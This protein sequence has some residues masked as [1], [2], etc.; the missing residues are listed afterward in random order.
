[1]IMG[2]TLDYTHVKEVYAR[3]AELGVAIP[4]F[5]AEDR[6]TMEAI[7]AAA[8]ELG[9]EIGVPDLPVAPA[10]TCRYPGRKQM[11]LVT[12]CGDP[13]LG[14]EMMHSDLRLFA[15]EHSPYRH[16]TILPHLDHAFPWYDMDVLI[17]YA[18][19]FASVM[20]DAS[21]RPFDE[22]IE[23]T[24]KYVERVKGKVVVEGGV[25]EVFEATGDKHKN[26][27]TTVGQAKRFLLE[28]GVDIIVP[29]VGTEHRATADKVKYNSKRAREISKKVGKIMCLHGTSSVPKED[30]ST[31]P[32]DG[33]VKINIF[34]ILAVK[35]GQS[36]ADVVL[37]NL[38]NIFTY[39]Q[40]EKYVSEGLL[41]ENVLKP[42][43]A[44]A[45]D[46][47]KPRLN[48]AANPIRRGAWFTIVKDICKDYMRVFN[49]ERYAC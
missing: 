14:M 11:T 33:F 43:Y 15:G 9:Q 6:E 7:L 5:C 35:G 23:I 18:D 25:D 46:G 3:A 8:Y 21:E 13:Y 29:N 30:L 20:C 24:A 41:S 39:D 49:Y 27:P 10:W 42:D 44:Q 34:T 4:T 32:Q 28:T 48:Y 36:V 16:L 19:K 26:E 2:L 47:L 31:L 40:L 1:M 37:H 22:N 45:F 38:G 12:Q 17:K